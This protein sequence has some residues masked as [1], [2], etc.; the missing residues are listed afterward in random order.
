MTVSTDRGA[1]C[2]GESIRINVDAK[3]H[4]SRR[5]VEIIASLKQA[6][7]FFGDPE[8]HRTVCLGTQC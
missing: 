1:Y 6:V 3:N 5:I 8:W 4:S 7:V 2:S